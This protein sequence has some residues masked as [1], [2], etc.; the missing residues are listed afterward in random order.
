MM[1]NQPQ[2]PDPQTRKRLV[3]QLREC[4]RNIEIWTLELDEL[5]AVLE[6]DLRKQRKAR[7]QKRS[8]TSF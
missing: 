8:T 5:L 1:T 4:S 7:L 6:A 2:I 3:E